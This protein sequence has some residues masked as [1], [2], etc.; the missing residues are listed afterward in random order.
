M[1]TLMEPYLSM[2]MANTWEGVDKTVVEKFAAQ[3]G[4]EPFVIFSWVDGDIL[5]LMFLLAG[6][7]AG[8]ISGYYYRELF[9]AKKSET[10]R[11]A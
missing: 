10:S 4:R 3:S 11:D 5:L 8:F 2:A 6:V 9:P 1:K 7:T